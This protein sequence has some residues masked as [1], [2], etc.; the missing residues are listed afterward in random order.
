MPAFGRSHEQFCYRQWTPGDRRRLCGARGAGRADRGRAPHLSAGQGHRITP[1]DEFVALA[2]DEEGL[3]PTRSPECIARGGCTQSTCSRACETRSAPTMSGSRREELAK[4]LEKLDVI[5]IEDAIYAFLA[6]EETPLAAFAQARDPYRQPV[7]AA[8]G[9]IDARPPRG[10]PASRRSGGSRHPSR[11]LGRLGLSAR[12]RSA[13]DGG[14][15]GRAHCRGETRGR[16]G[17]PAPGPHDARRARPAASLSSPAR[18]SRSGGAPKPSSRSRR[19]KASPSPRRA[20][21]PPW[22]DMRRTPFASRLRRRPCQPC[23]SHLRRCGVSRCATR[24]R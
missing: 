13:L 24:S 23:V 7:E 3:V 21:L 1:R 20:P 6:P 12:G 19:D 11:R 5:A 16:E 8:R 14:R 2:F 17:A 10:A 18:A 22:R 4:L 15:D 9:R